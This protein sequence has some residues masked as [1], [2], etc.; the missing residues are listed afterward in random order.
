[1][2][3]KMDMKDYSEKHWNLYFRMQSRSCF[4]VVLEVQLYFLHIFK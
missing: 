1:M 2:E 3:I 4:S